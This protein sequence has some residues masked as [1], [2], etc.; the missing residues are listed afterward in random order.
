MVLML[1]HL[2]LIVQEFSSCT[3][4]IMI[5][6]Y[7]VEACYQQSPEYSLQECLALDKFLLNV[8]AHI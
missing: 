5:I 2:G 1:H 6:T 8:F 7:L 3:K 4:F